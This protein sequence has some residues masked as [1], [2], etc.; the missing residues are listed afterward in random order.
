[1]EMLLDFMKALDYRTM[2]LVQAQQI[3]PAVKHFILQ[4]DLPFS[5]IP[6]QFITIHFEWEGKP[7]K[8][9]YS[10]ANAPLASGNIEFAANYVAHGPGSQFLFNL[11]LNTPLHVT[12]PYGRLVLKDPTPE[13]YIFIGTGTG[14]TPYRAMLP[15]LEQKLSENPHLAVVF[16]QGV[17]TH[18]DQLYATDFLNL[19]K[20]YNRATFLSCFSRLSDGELTAGERAGYVQKSIPALKP[21][22]IADMVYLCGNPAMIDEVYTLLTQL[23]FSASHVLR[24]KYISN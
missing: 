1:M 9:S 8:R 18:V 24:E 16:L 14:V 22:P 17:R 13:R 23:G 21:N 10:I 11:Q 2:R 15:L 12:G 20:K 4:P 3:T 7:Y 5:F 19:S 6:G